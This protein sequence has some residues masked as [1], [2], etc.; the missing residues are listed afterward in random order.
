MEEEEERWRKRKRR[1]EGGREGKMEEEEE[2]ERWRDG[3]RGEMEEEEEMRKGYII[4]FISNEIDTNL[5][6]DHRSS[7]VE[8][9]RPTVQQ[10]SSSHLY[11]NCTC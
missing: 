2:K 11:C 1:R 5:H 9:C 7:R 8:Y 4:I 6:K 3:G 10:L